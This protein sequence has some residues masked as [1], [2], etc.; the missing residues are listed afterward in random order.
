MAIDKLGTPPP[1]YIPDIEPPPD[2]KK[3]ETKDK[4]IQPPPVNQDAGS[5]DSDIQ[6]SS[7]GKEVDTKDTD[8][9]SKTPPAGL[10]GA[11]QT[12]DVKG[13][14]NLDG[15][16]VSKP[17]SEV[18]N[19]VSP[20]VSAP[21]P[22]Q[23]PLDRPKL[24]IPSQATSMSIGDLIIFVQKEIQ[25][26]SEALAKAQDASIKADSLKQQAAQNS[27]IT[28]LNEATEKILEAQKMQEDLEIANW[29]MMAFSIAFALCS[30]GT[31]ALLSFWGPL[32]VALVVIPQVP[33][34]GKNLN[35]W[36]TEGIG[37]GVGALQK[38]IAKETVKN[39]CKEK[40]LDPSK[41][42]MDE[43]NAEI[44]E[45]Q[46]YYAMAIMI[47]IQITIAVVQCICT[48]GMN[49]PAAVSNGAKD[50]AGTTVQVT[51]DV[52]KQAA[53]TIVK[54]SI[55]TAKQAVE[56]TV[57]EAANAAK[58]V[59]ETTVK[60]TTKITQ[61]VAQKAVE[62]A[63]D[64]ADDVAKETVNQASQVATTTTNAVSDTVSKATDA[65]TKVATEGVAQLQKI[66]KYIDVAKTLGTTAK[67]IAVAGVTID[68]SLLQFEASE[69]QANAEKIKAY[70]KFLQEIL[71]SDQEFLAELIQ[72]QATIAETTR[73]IL[74]TEHTTNLHIANMPSNA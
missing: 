61:D 18:V 53:E 50:V 28:A 65:G 44:E 43:I 6:P 49:A 56:T 32:V 57:K 19:V 34:E 27:Q 47:T 4:D 24:I 63:A 54:E 40:G 69:G 23:T 36:I 15:I 5:K 10:G 29:A 7:D 68:I 12:G 26:T 11:G 9:E 41:V 14:Q 70:V 35:G 38:E 66:N 67:D 45:N 59:A 1:T 51:T 55:N 46:G 3:S 62:T 42:N 39:I 71:K 60:E 25:K 48:A 58:Q 33:I 37:Q 21:K 74:Q 13:P 8:T 22:N 64:L 17:I 73:G 20:T 72:M 30:F 31:S 52:A 2:N 16:G